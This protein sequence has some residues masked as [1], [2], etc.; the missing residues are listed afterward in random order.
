MITYQEALQKAAKY[1]AYQERCQFELRRK[2]RSWGVSEP[3]AETIIAELIVQGFLSEQ[4]YANAFV[5]G[6][7]HLKSWG[8]GKIILQLRQQGISER[9]IKEALAAVDFSD[10]A[11]RLAHTAEKW[12]RTHADVPSQ[13]RFW[14]LSAHL[15]AKGFEADAVQAYIDAQGDF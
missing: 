1:C 4:R 5:S 10:Y 12:L 8:R 6:K 14:K 7:Y 2:L 3:D 11:E 15:Y 13:Q 9:C